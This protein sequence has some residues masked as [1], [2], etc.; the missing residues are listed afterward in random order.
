ML[1]KP[2]VF[3]G[4]SG[5]VD[6]SVALALLKEGGYD[7]TGVF[8]KVWQPDF[9]PCDWK[10]EKRSAMRVCATLDVPFMTL[11]CTDEYKK[12]VVDYMI[13]EYRAGRVPNPDIFCNKYVKFGVFL[14]KALELGAD[15][16]ATGHYAK[17]EVKSKKYELLESVDKEKD[18]SYFLYTLTQEQ[19]SHTLFPVGK[20]TKPEVRKLAVKFGLPTAT[21][22]DSQGLC[23]IGKVDMKDFL[24]HYMKIKPG[25]V[26]NLDK[27]VIGNHDGAFFYTIGQRHGFTILKKSSVDPRFFVISKDIENNTITV[28]SKENDTKEIYSISKIS[29]FDLHFVSGF[30]SNSESLTVRIRY[31]QEKQKCTLTKTKD[32]YDISFNELQ[33]GIAIGQSA[34]LYD[35]NK[36]VGGGIIEKV[37]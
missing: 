33:N 36:V 34:V 32:G 17:V 8:L 9:L 37:Y 21:K 4:V 6:S 22:K 23:F 7:V 12:E 3:V 15:F 20:M 24:S 30:F 11:D 13:S 35:D 19:L 31:R 27:E 16:I 2:K 25:N 29:I 10:E 5:G 14:N 26:L 18:Q 1:K 28:A